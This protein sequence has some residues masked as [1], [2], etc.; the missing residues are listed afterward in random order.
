MS[1]ATDE[2]NLPAGHYA[3]PDPLVDSVIRD[4]VV[5]HRCEVE[6]THQE[7]IT[8]VCGCPRQ[9]LMP[10]ELVPTEDV[11]YARIVADDLRN[12]F[13]CC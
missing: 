2:P 11:E 10:V 7:W 8:V 9:H 6:Y 13:K 1:E 5:H 3:H 4:M 12:A